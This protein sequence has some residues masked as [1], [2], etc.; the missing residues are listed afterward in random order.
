MVAFYRLNEDVL[1]VK[2]IDVDN[3]INTFPELRKW[4]RE[5]P[6]CHT[7]GYNPKMPDSVGGSLDPEYAARII[8]NNLYPLKVND[9][10]ICIICANHISKK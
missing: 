6:I 4:I 7:K 3:Y 8:K 1:A 5:C 2:R 9:M 10:G